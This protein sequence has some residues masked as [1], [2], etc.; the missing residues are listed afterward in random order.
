MVIVG[1]NQAYHLIL[2]LMHGMCFKHLG[3][4]LKNT[5][6]NILLGNGT[7]RLL[8]NIAPKNSLTDVRTLA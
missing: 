1:D 8:Q 5:F 2:F 6:I 3:F 7:H 4:C